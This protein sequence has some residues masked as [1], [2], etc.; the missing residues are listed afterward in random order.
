[1]VVAAAAAMM[2]MMMSVTGRN[3]CTS[4][5]GVGERKLAEGK[6]AIQREGGGGGGV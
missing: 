2:M 1:M 4:D 5:G 6:I 3:F